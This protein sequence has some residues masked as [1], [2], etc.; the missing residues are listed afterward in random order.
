MPMARPKPNN[1]DDVKAD[2]AMRA[3]VE[4]FETM[5]R[6]PS[7]CRK[8]CLQRIDGELVLRQTEVSAAIERAIAS[9][10]GAPS[11]LIRPLLSWRSGSDL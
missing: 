6:E 9:L 5:K 7:S 8:Y 11:C 1:P 4:F 2:A 3:L 10:D